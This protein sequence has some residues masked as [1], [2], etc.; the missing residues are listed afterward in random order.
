MRLDKKELKARLVCLRFPSLD[1]LSLT[2]LE[3][4]GTSAN[5]KMERKKTLTTEG[6]SQLFL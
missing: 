2:L 3:I 6:Q 4:M 5:K 1:T